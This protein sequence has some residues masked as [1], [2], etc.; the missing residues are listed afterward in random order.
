[1]RWRGRLQASGLWFP[2][3]W[4]WPQRL[5]PCWESGSRLLEAPP[6]WYLLFPS[7]R[8]VDAEHCAGIPV[9]EVAGG[10]CSWAD[11]RP[12]AGHLLWK[13]QGR[14]YSAPL[15]GL[16]AVD[17]DKLWESSSLSY[18]EARAP[19][20][21]KRIAV[22]AP[23]LLE[24]VRSI[25]P[26]VQPP[27]PQQEDFLN[28]LRQSSPTGGPRNPLLGLFDLL[29]SFFTSPENQQYVKKMVD[30]FER[31]QWQEALRYAI[32]LDNSVPNRQWQ[33]FL[34]VLRPR[35]S[36]DFTALTRA[37]SAIGTSLDGLE[38]LR[39]LY[40]K[41]LSNLIAAGRIEE[42]AFLQ[43]EILQEVAAAVDLLEAHGKLQ[44]AARLATLKGLPAAQQ[45]RLW[46]MA[47]DHQQAL[48][49]ARRYYAHAEAAL[50]LRSR[51]P[52]LL[53]AF[54]KLWALDLAA[55]GRTAE[56]LKAGWEVRSDLPD[57][58]HWLQE[59]LTDGGHAALEAMA[60]C[61]PDSQLRTKLGL[62]RYLEQWFADKDP[63]SHERQRKLL[64]LLARRPFLCEDPEMLAWAQ[65]TARR[66]MRQASGPFPIGGLSELNFLIQVA[67]DPWLKADRPAS[68]P[69]ISPRLGL[70]K[71]VIESRGLTP[72]WDAAILS[73]GRLLVALGHAGLQLLSRRGAVAQRFDIPA[74]RLVAPLEGERFLVLSGQRLAGY[75]QGRCTPWCSIDLD[76]FAEFHDG[77]HWLVWVGRDIHQIDL[78]RPLEF[79]SLTRIQ[80]PGQPL[81]V[82][83]GMR[84]LA[85]ETGRGI[86][87]WDYPGLHPAHRGSQTSPG[88]GLNV[89]TPTGL[90]SLLDSRQ[91]YRCATHPLSI[92][93]QAPK[94]NHQ[95]GYILVE[96]DLRGGK[97][98]L[99]FPQ[100]HPDLQLLLEL[101]LSTRLSA[102]IQGHY[103][104]VGDDQGRLLVAD[105]QSRQWL[106]QH[107]L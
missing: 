53:P 62:A 23:A 56:A 59:A 89:L 94:A 105:L 46:F 13:W 74:H 5:A 101:P 97:S 2:P 49:L 9:V 32:P 61:L 40:R 70:W 41:A 102:R 36:L 103:L 93:G 39:S 80:L 6:G 79:R 35:N 27:A 26:A 7:P 58:S 76:G 51:N 42:A 66:L 78:T 50:Q 11:G 85:V 95:G 96:S 84:Q 28:R 104:I 64:G 21:V 98:L 106:R 8:E 12:N 86:Q 37:G 91:N 77:Y 25:L 24:R 10:Y 34:G 88:P 52:G 99:V 54:Q 17:L 73:D 38:L 15:S 45:V 82:C 16:E 60:L 18:Q 57:Y 92:E 4:Q 33:Q 107:F 55:V 43:G 44:A 1:M 20:T 31:Q 67:Q 81:R 72:L 3:G 65:N 100:A 90:E 22:P 19:A 48:T 83:L 29:K 47:G 63:G 69:N 14:C 30:L 71:T 75:M 87:F 68:L